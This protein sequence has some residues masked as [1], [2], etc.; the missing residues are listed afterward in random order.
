MKMQDMVAILKT[1]ANR[2][3]RE[4]PNFKKWLKVQRYVYKNLLLRFIIPFSGSMHDK[5]II[6]NLKLSVILIYI[7]VTIKASCV[8]PSNRVKDFKYLPRY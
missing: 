2:I 7:T 3:G 6:F 5:E 4:N 1:L 8:N